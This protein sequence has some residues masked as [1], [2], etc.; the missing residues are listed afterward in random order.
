MKKPATSVSLKDRALRTGQKLRQY[1]VLLFVLFI[2]GIYGFLSWRVFTL[3]QAQPDPAEVSAELKTAGVPNIPT[4]VVNKMQ[5]LQDNSVSVQSL[6]DE[7]R[8][9]PF[10]E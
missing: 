1:S 5:Q 6:F 9:N 4:D 7:A 10:Q 3:D 2:F 8:R